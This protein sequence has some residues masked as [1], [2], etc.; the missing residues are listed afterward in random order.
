MIPVSSL[1]MPELDIYRERAETRL[2]HYYEPEPGLF[3]AETPM[4]IRRALDAGYRPVSLLGEE[5]ILEKEL[6]ELEESL[7]DIPVYSASSAWGMCF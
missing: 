5:K 1:N 6:P 2:Y 7:G 3:I 4:V